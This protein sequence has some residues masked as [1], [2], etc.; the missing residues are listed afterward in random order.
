MSTM[1]S[2]I[3]VEPHNTPKQVG[4]EKA[5][6]ECDGPPSNRKSRPSVAPARLAHDEVFQYT[7]YAIV[8][9][10][11]VPRARTTVREYGS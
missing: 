3:L 7:Q 8:K 5:P 10:D 11:N 4:P 9:L 1:H 6:T 2:R